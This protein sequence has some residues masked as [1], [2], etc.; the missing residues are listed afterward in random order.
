M[1][2]KKVLLS[3]LTGFLLAGCIPGF[4]GSKVVTEDTDPVE[5]IRKEKKFLFRMTDISF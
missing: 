5:S 2:L 3:A 4:D 1:K